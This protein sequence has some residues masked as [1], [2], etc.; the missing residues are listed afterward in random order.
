MRV[1]AIQLAYS[2]SEPIGDRV[3]RAVALVQTQRDA[4]LVILPE[5]WAATGF[6][7]R[8]WG[9]DAA[10]IESNPAVQQLQ[11][12]AREIG[13]YVHAGSF[14]EAGPAA[15]ARLDAAGGDVTALPELPDGQRELWNTSALL[16]PQGQIV[17]TYRKIHRFGFGSGEPKLLDPGEDIVTARLSFPDGEVTVGLATCYD[18]RFPELFRA[19]ID[20][21][22]EMFLVPAAWPAARVREW[23]VLA[24]ARAIESLAPVIAVNTAGFHGRAQMGGH[25]V[26]LDAS[27]RELAVGGDTETIITADI[28]LAATAERRESFP[29]LADRRL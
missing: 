23:D 1:S 5:L 3:M 4:D 7:Y 11:Q 24:R 13:A 19:L 21:G 9:E 20:Q 16:D 26:I 8:K 27:G 22:A 17:A 18:F 12:A 25:S 10:P 15:T 6:S 28:D 14:I 2:D 29:A